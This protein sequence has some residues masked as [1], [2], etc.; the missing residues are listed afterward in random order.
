MR[1]ALF[2]FAIVLL[3]VAA[4]AQIKVHDNGHVS[5]GCLTQNFGVQVQPNGYTYF[6]TQSASSGGWVTLAIAG[7]SYQKHWIVEKQYTGG[8]YPLGSHM[9]YVNGNGS[10]YSVSRYSISP[11]NENNE[12]EGLKPID[13]EA[14]LAAVLGMEGYYYE[15][16]QAV[17]PEEITNSEYI[18][19]NAMEGMI[20]DL[21]KSNVRLSTESLAEV[22]PDAV[23]TDPEARLCVDYDAIVTML[24]QAVKQQQEEINLLRK[25]LE[26]NGLLEPGK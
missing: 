26:E 20:G 4:Q 25:T 3:A 15:D 5:L 2:T 6:R 8:T 23:R 24:T 7:H 12:K 22:L 13:G 11:S 16:I 21:E 14:A 18:D 17:T 9:F 1:K 19:E 10:L